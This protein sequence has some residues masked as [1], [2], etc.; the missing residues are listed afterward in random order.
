MNDSLLLYA[1]AM[2]IIIKPKIP[3]HVLADCMVPPRTSQV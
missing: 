1:K 2:A 3:S